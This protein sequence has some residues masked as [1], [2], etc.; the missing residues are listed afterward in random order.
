[1]RLCPCTGNAHVLAVII[2]IVV[3]VGKI[4]PIARAIEFRDWRLRT[5]RMGY[6]YVLAYT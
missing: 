4:L 3:L 2:S 1:M 6:L 5:A